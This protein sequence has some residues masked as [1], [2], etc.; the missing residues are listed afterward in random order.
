MY[1]FIFSWAHQVGTIT[2]LCCWSS[3]DTQMTIWG[4]AVPPHK[5]ITLCSNTHSTILIS[6]P[7]KELVHLNTKYVEVQYAK[8]TW[9]SHYIQPAQLFWLFWPHNVRCVT[10]PPSRKHMTSYL[11]KIDVDGWQ[12]LL[13]ASTVFSVLLCTEADV[14]TWGSKF[15]VHCHKEVV[16]PDWMH[17]ARNSVHFCKG[18]CV[19]KVNKKKYLMRPWTSIC[20][21][22]CAWA[23][24]NYI[25]SQK[26]L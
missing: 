1:S 16:C 6:E 18:G 19:L 8:N 3:P 25:S 4:I 26:I 21:T 9:M 17:S 2:L 14:G 24:L 15:K 13:S 22:G 12:A 20:Y 11:T 10:Y 5:D 23:D 7:D